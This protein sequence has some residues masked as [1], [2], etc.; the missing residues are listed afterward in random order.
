MKKLP[1]D[2]E[3]QAVELVAVKAEESDSEILRFLELI[4]RWSAEGSPERWIVKVPEVVG[5]FRK[6]ILENRI[7]EGVDPIRAIQEWD[8]YLEDLAEGRK[9]GRFPTATGWRAALR[10]QFE[11]VLP[12]KR[13]YERNGDEDLERSSAR[14]GHEK[15]APLVQRSASPSAQGSNGRSQAPPATDDPYDVAKRYLTRQVQRWNAHLDPAQVI[16]ELEER[17][18]RDQLLGGIRKWRDDDSKRL[19]EDDDLTDVKAGIA[20][21]AKNIQGATSHAVEAT[22][23]P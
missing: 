12:F 9:G 11:K 6:E 2:F 3:A 21:R 1:H 16:R 23:T 19:L 17:F 4:E 22:A 7:G 10:Y 5:W 13:T 20:Y 8:E 18:P 15:E 14:F